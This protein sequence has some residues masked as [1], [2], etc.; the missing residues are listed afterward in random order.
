MSETTIKGRK[1]IICVEILFLQQDNNKVVVVLLF[2]NNITC[3]LNGF[4]NL[5]ISSAFLKI[6]Y[7][8]RAI[9][10][11]L[12]KLAYS[13]YRFLSWPQT[14]FSGPSQIDL[15]EKVEGPRCS[16]SSMEHHDIGRGRHDAGL[17][18]FECRRAGH[19]RRSLPATTS[20]RRKGAGDISVSHYSHHHMISESK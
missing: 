19:H 11:F 8:L 15:T 20:R 14:F 2:S 5:N 18:A 12:L 7:F 16:D 10:S 13:N 17:D 1:K 4:L 6:N 3:S 9:F